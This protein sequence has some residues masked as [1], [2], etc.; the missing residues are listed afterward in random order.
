MNIDHNP[1]ITTARL[2]PATSR[3]LG[4]WLGVLSM[5]TLVSPATADAAPAFRW[6]RKVELPQL[7]ET[8]LLA[9]P[10][11]S[12][13]FAATQ[14]DFAD[15]RLRDD[16]EENVAF[17]VRTA[18]TTRERTVRKTW[19]AKQRGA[20]PL[21]SGGLEIFLDLEDKSPTPQ[22][23]RVISPLR[24]FE[25]QVRVF[26]SA[27]GSQWEPAGPPTVIFDYSR[28]VDVR[29]V[30]APIAGGAHRH[31]RLVIDDVTAEQASQ[32]LEL[33]RRL[34]G[35]EETR[36][37]ERTTILRRPFRVDSVEFYRDDVENQPSGAQTVAYPVT[38]LRISEDAKNKQTLVEFASQREPLTSLKLL[39]DATNFSRAAMLQV[40]PSDQASAPWR[41]VAAATLSE[42]SLEAMHKS[43][44][45]MTFSEQRHP[46]YR[47]V[48]D[49]R[50]S[51]AVPIRGVEVEGPVYQLVFLGVPGQRL[52][53]DYGSPDARA[54]TYDTAAVRASLA[55]GYAPAVVKLGE[56]VE[57]TGAAPPFRWSSLIEDA[58]VVIGVIVVL[59]VVLGWGLFRAS[60]RLE[61][62][63]QE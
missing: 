3:A 58:R 45:S 8:A 4:L 1:G 63:P 20:K 10:F 61:S 15:L 25:H 33:T 34:T 13:L 35:S 50:D 11:D 60:R 2:G 57:N 5:T 6:S 42:F 52:T 37:D 7:G 14:A 30:A 46:R 39:T 38:D 59:T 22:G 12:G 21:E 24:D 47:L 19:P 9:I 49:N 29:S 40:P 48:L 62:T 56:A 43:E 36:R 32:L 44:L 18:P 26:S 54:A 41:T 17:I 16:H 31:F 53:L 23:L 55:A 27:D 51:P 28:F